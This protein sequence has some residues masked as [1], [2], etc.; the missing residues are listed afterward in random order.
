M[1]KFYNKKS[2]FSLIEL[3]VAMLITSILLLG[4]ISLFSNSS[5]LNR[6]QA[7]LAILQENGRYAISR[8][9][10]DV[11]NA[12][13]KH[14]ASIALPRES[15]T[16]WKQGADMTEWQVATNVL[17][18]NGLP[19]VGDVKIDLATDADQLADT[20]SFAGQT[21][22]PL[23]PSYFIRGHECTGS[24]CLPDFV[25]AGSDGSITL[26]TPG[27]GNGQRGI[28]SDVLTVRY[29]EGGVEVVAND[30]L[31][32]FTLEDPVSTTYTGNTLI[33]D[34]DN[35]YV[36]PATWSGVDVNLQQ[37]SG[38]TIPQYDGLA[39]TK[40]YRLTQ[41]VKTVTYFIQVDNDP[42]SSTRKISSLYRSENGLVQ[43]LVEGV[44]R[45]DFFYLVQLQTG[46][47]VRMTADQVNQVTGGG[48]LD[49]DGALDSIQGCVTPPK[50]DYLPSGAG[51]AN[52]RGCLWRSV[53]AVEVHLLL[54]TVNNSSSEETEP[55]IYSPDG[56]TPQTPGAVL[57]NGLDRGKMYRR[58][59]TAI[60]PIRSYTL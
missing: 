8:I 30:G 27:S 40:A 9:K 32:G 6:A 53:Y 52:D 34:C 25:D 49:N 29:L 24:T 15:I 5:A 18:T 19:N 58:E 38:A 20:F 22:Y 43:Q 3:L 11:E 10:S 54:N 55:F 46:H 4:V 31:G 41:D 2:G 59:F 48:D 33:A 14:C 50:V 21:S 17:F 51:L 1:N 42:N 44:E 39:D 57:P 12:G 13:R 60:I 47:V 26:P 35:S 56:T 36:A 28:N 23:D 37:P 45:L 16:D 7:G